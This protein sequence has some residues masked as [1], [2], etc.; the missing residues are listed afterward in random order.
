MKLEAMLNPSGVAVF[1][2]AAPGKL[3]NILIGRLLDGGMERVYAINPKRQPVREANGYASVLEVTDSI[4][5]AVIAA[6]AST[7]SDIMEDCGKKGIKAAVIIS[8][9]FSEA[10]NKEEEKKVIEIASKYGI[11]SIGPNCA[12]LVNTHAKLVA[13]LE[14]MPPK[15]NISIISQSGAI[16]G[17]FMA[18]S[19]ED[20]VGIAKFLSY[21]N[22]ADLTVIELLEYLKDDADTKVIALYLET[23][24]EGRKFMETVKTVTKTKPVVVV[25]SGRTNTGQRAALSHTGS[26]AGSDAVFDAALRQCGAIRAETLQDL[27]DVCKGFALLPEMKGRELAVVTNSGGPGVMS[28]DK[29]EELK[30]KVS[31]PDEEIKK[32]LSSILPSYAG[33]RNPID[34]T[35]EGTGEQY[36]SATEIALKSADGALVLYVGTPYLACMPVAEG[37]VRAYKKT[38]KPVAAM[39]QVGNDIKESIAYLRENGIPCFTSGERAV[40]VLSAMSGYFEYRQNADNSAC[41]EPVSKKGNL[42][43]ERKRLLEPEA[44]SLLKAYGIPVPLSAYVN[45]ID[46]AVNEGRKLG[47]PLVMKV[48]SP[49]IIHKSDCGGVVLDID[50]EEKIAE[51]YKKIESSA[52]GRDFKGAIIY[53]MLKG[54]REVIIGLTRDVQFGPVIVFGMGGIY[55]EALKDVTFRVAPVNKD[56][57]K[58]MISE[59]KMFPVLKGIRGQKGIDIEALAEAIS[60]FS[61]LPFVY[62]DIAEADL[63][64]VFAFEDGLYAA[65]VRILGR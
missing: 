49:D 9:G 61:E 14:T 26:M 3:A 15:G 37:I 1:G 36:S 54:G 65:D 18:L 10:G 33:I 63:N 16:G 34:L 19:A 30:L 21:G 50:S 23:V 64:P 20:G 35:V 60:K 43:E 12:G 8:S 22:G 44:M 52:E 39:M 57:A 38:G 59:I 6:P 41:F 28:T 40:Y 2:S 58:K 17:S 48:V 27:F 56:A 62:E 51:A 31:E 24:S 7:V 29:A 5:M 47:Y 55:T 42:F 11:R 46:D 32:E 45:N 13:T 53:P 4:D 25:K